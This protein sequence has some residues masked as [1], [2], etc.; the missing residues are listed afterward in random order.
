MR[1]HTKSF[2][3]V[4]LRNSA[5]KYQFKLYLVLSTYSVVTSFLGII[6]IELPRQDLLKPVLASI[7]AP[8]QSILCI[9]LAEGGQR[10]MPT[11]S[12]YALCT[13][14]VV[15]RTKPSCDLQEP[16]TAMYF[17]LLILKN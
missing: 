16:S 14:Y 3:V 1:F 10:N 17:N 4:G 13:L 12:I 7:T 2:F 9:R 11:C 5:E 8:V 6:G 15:H